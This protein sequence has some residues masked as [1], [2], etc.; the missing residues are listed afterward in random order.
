MG[1]ARSQPAATVALPL[2]AEDSVQIKL[3][4]SRIRVGVTDVEADSGQGRAGGD[5][6]VITLIGECRVDAGLR[7][8]GAKR[9]GDLLV[10]A[11]RP[12]QCPSVDRR[13]TRV[14]D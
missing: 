2:M 11:P 4:W 13:G 6:R 12:R 1:E 10:P 14:F 5:R 3:R 7:I 8:E 9:L